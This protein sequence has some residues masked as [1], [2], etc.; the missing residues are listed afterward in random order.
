MPL[1]CLDTDGRNIQAF[2][3]P[4]EEWAVLRL[5]NKKNRHLR[6]PCCASQVVMKVSPRGTKFF[7]HSA[8]GDCATAPE[9]EEH[10]I[11]KSMAVE[12][13]RR[14]GWACATEVAGLTPTGEAWTADVLAEKGKHR[15]AFEIQWSSQTAEETLYRQERYRESG[16][17][18]LWL[19]RRA[20]F[21]ISDA[22]PAVCVGGDLSDGFD[23]RIPMYSS[24]PPRDFN[25][26]ARWAQVLPVEEFFDALFAKRFRYGT[27]VGTKAEVVVHSGVLECWKRQCQALTR[28]VTFIE[29]AAGPHSCSFTV[30][31]LAA[32]PDLL[33]HVL[34]QIPPTNRLG[35]IKRRY[36][37]TLNES[38]MSNGCYRCDALVG[39]HFEHDAW[40]SDNAVLTRFPVT[41]SDRWQQVVESEHGRFGWGVHESGR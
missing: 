26:P 8:R 4:D 10:R 38:Y 25:N 16:V 24:V 36:S 35:A 27:P 22:L 34:R 40:Y 28:I 17:R 5:D 7:A 1:R 9:T 30:Q 19:F 13:A 2:D 6:M 12:A 31:S 37:N 20:G 32:Y 14:A 15:I 41:I 23:I 21:P 39:A 3:L 18:C 11:L 29:I 33:S